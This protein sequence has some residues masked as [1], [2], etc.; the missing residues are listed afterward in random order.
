VPGALQHNPG[1]ARRI[2]SLRTSGADYEIRVLGSKPTPLRDLYHALLRSPWRVVLA[3]V[4]AVYLLL[5]ATF[6]AAYLLSGGV[7]NARPH[8]FLDAFFFSVQTMG[9]IGY[10]NMYPES[11]AANWLVTIES[12]LGLVLTALGTGLVFAKLSRPTARVMFSRH[13]V[14]C[15]V[16]GAPTLMFRVGN[17]RGNSIMDAQFRLV[18]TRTE[19]TREGEL[20][21]RSYE[22]ALTRDRAI[23]LNRALTVSHR[24]EGASPFV[25]ESA[26]SVIAQEYELQVMVLGIDDAAMQTVH[27]SHVYFARDILWNTRLADALSEQPDGSLVLDLSKFHEVEPIKP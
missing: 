25:G 6:A 21:Y 2:V 4:V 8:S 3:L 23:S 10:G 5:N 24:I 27:A 20:F 26:E 9:T 19:H 12:L 11:L 14:I 18:A 1:M 17:E 7:H 22:A 16:N 15:P 13:A